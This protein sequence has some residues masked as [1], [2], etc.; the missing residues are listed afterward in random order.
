MGVTSLYT[1]IL[2]DESIE[3]I[4][5]A[6]ENFYKDKTP[7]PTHYLREMLRLILKEDESIEIICKAYENFYKDKTPIPAH[8]LREM[9]RLILKEDSFRSTTI[10]SK[11]VFKPIV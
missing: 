4:C 1:I 8:Y 9:L 6:Y 7:I 11:I 5:K 2:Q 10:L 3:I